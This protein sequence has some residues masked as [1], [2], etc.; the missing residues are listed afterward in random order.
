MAVEG[1]SDR[2]KIEL[3]FSVDNMKTSVS[4]RKP[5]N[6]AAE[7]GPDLLEIG[8]FDVTKSVGAKNP[9]HAGR[10]ETAGPTFTNSL[11]L[12]GLLRY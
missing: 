6:A 3:A 8:I 1:K 7:P 11:K 9:C 4:G 12:F 2:E 5:L 10:L